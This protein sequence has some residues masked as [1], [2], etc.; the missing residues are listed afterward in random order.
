MNVTGYIV[1]GKSA[2]SD[3]RGSYKLRPF[4]LVQIFCFAIEHHE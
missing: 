2:H 4:L 1:I 3:F